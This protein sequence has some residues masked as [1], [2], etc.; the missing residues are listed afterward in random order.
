MEGGKPNS[1]SNSRD[2]GNSVFP[3]KA[4]ATGAGP[5]GR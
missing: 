1:S 4:P 3:A 5:G 2:D